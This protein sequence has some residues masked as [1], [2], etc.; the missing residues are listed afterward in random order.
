VVA[1]SSS[2][3]QPILEV[4]LCEDKW[5]EFASSVGLVGVGV[6]NYYAGKTSARRSLA[7]D[8]KVVEEL[9]ADTVHLGVFVLPHPYAVEDFVFTATKT[10]VDILVTMKSKP[11]L[12][13][14][15]ERMDY[16]LSEAKSQGFSLGH[17]RVADMHNS[18]LVAIDNL[19]Y[20]AA[21]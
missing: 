10:S 8:L 17:Y 16:Y 1:P 9:F 11:H 3:A 20:N 18:L 13:A 21:F 6:Y 15:L 2:V 4:V 14:R 19:I 12:Q 5:D 7:N